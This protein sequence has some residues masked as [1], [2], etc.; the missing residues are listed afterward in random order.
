MTDKITTTD[1]ADFGYRELGLLRELIEA[2]E[3]HGLPEDF[4]S[5]GVTPMFNTHSGE[6]FLTNDEYQVAMERGGRLESWYTLSYTGHEGFLDDLY[7]D[8]ERGEIFY[9]DLDEL[10]DI[11]ERN[12][13]YDKAEYVREVIEQESAG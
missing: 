6:V 4:E 9:R 11:L 3:D 8:F 5:C 12:H 1:L 10:A 13:E 7:E 2:M